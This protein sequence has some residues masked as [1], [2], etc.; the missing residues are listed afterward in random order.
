MIGSALSDGGEGRPLL[1]PLPV[2]N[3][4]WNRQILP[5][6]SS[7]CSCPSVCNTLTCTHT[8]INIDIYVHMVH[9]WVANMDPLIVPTVY[10]RSFKRAVDQHVTADMADCVI[11]STIFFIFITHHEGPTVTLD[12]YFRNPKYHRGRGWICDIT[13]CRLNLKE[14]VRGQ[15]EAGTP[16]EAILARLGQANGLLWVV[17]GR[18]INSKW[19]SSIR[20]WI[21]FHPGRGEGK[22]RASNCG[23]YSV[24]TQAKPTQKKNTTQKKW[25]LV[26]A[27]TSTSPDPSLAVAA[28]MDTI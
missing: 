16:V 4:A 26:L 1:S 8:Y 25:T 12:F 3:P 2:S 28:E 15:L 5:H 22:R 6:L 7:Q 14:T 13:V 10:S 27:H 17:T 9:K 24:V 19:V 11:F 20:L 21:W 18:W 23:G